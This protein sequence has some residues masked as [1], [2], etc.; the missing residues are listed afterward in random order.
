MAAAS[1]ALTA[2]LLPWSSAF[3][4]LNPWSELGPK[5]SLPAAAVA[6]AALKPVVPVGTKFKLDMF[7]L[8][9]LMQDDDGDVITTD[10]VMV[11]NI[12]VTQTQEPL[13]AVIR[14][15]ILP[16][17]AAKYC[18]VR[19]S[20]RDPVRLQVFSLQARCDSHGTQFQ[21]PWLYT[22][23]PFRQWMA[24]M[25]GPCVITVITQEF[26]AALRARAIP[27]ALSDGR[28]IISV[29][30]VRQDG[31]LV[32][33]SENADSEGMTAMLVSSAVNLNVDVGFAAT[34]LGSVRASLTNNPGFLDVFGDF[35]Q[36]AADFG[37]FYGGTPGVPLD[38]NATTI[39][40]V[41][42]THPTA[43][44]IDTADD[45]Q[46]VCQ[47]ML[48]WPPVQDAADVLYVHVVVGNY[49]SSQT[50]PAALSH[51]D[52]RA[53][54]ALPQAVCRVHD[55]KTMTV[56]A[57][58][59]SWRDGTPDGCLHPPLASLQPMAMQSYDGDASGSVV[60]MGS[61]ALSALPCDGSVIL[62]A[63]AALYRA[64]IGPGSGSNTAGSGAST[65]AEKHVYL[66]VR[67]PYVQA[68]NRAA[69]LHAYNTALA[70]EAAGQ[71]VQVHVSVSG[72]GVVLAKMLPFQDCTV[73]KVQTAFE[74]TAL[75]HP[76]AP[77]V[78]LETETH[79]VVAC[80]FLRTDNHHCVYILCTAIP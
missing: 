51:E 32:G 78:V 16:Q 21:V 19:R 54:A 22:E 50:Q 67:P 61:A 4:R 80:E 29:V 31:Y 74:V 13:G 23:A 47:L 79:A 71:A 20:G 39:G 5:V 34:P 12:V 25:P 3:V 66:M 7:V 6:R 59:S 1:L 75:A 40:A 43:L 2:A 44:E 17:L 35:A 55:S 64:T 9:A 53:L 65:S 63:A 72:A 8:T 26:V 14:D 58:R 41:L 52:M 28:G 11:Q 33:M 48:V 42:Q 38:N 70:L 10:G 56:D 24:A 49:R 77:T 27:A 68:S 30:V 36:A 62:S 57:L 37:V 69:A 45:N 15:Q 76:F 46:N 18:R 60:I 73:E